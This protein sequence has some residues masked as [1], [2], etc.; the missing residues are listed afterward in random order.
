MQTEV[1]A[2]GNDEHLVHVRLPQSLYDDVYAVQL[3]KLTSKARLPGFRPGKMPQNMVEKQFAPQAHEDTINEL[4]QRHYLEA[5]E[6]S[7]LTPAIQPEIDLPAV[8]VG[9]GFEFTL[10]VTTWPVVAAD[11]LHTLAVT[12]TTVRVDESDVQAVIDRLSGS[13]VRYEIEEGR[14]AEKGDQL[15]IDFEGFLGD[16]PF[17]GGKGENVPLVLGEGRFIPGFEE[18]LTGAAANEQRTLN[19]TFP[20]Q[21]QAAHL[22]GQAARFECRVRSVGRPVTAENED[23]LATMLGFEDGAALRADIEKRLGQEA[24][25]SSYEAT[26]NSAFDALLAAHSV[27]LPAGLV[28]QEMDSAMRRMAQ[29]MKQQGM[30]VDMT[31]F[32]EPSLQDGV[33]ARAERSLKLSVLL[34]SVRDQGSL[35]VSEETIEAE[36]ERMAQHYPT[37][38]HE[39]FKKWMRGQRDQFE[40]MQERLLEQAC[41]A[42]ILG[43]AKRE[44]R[45]INLA[46]WQSEREQ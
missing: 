34:Q 37:E 5:L 1:K 11:K 36:L 9:A 18:Q 7:G 16:T 32:N 14:A 12:E 24:G 35:T 39:E 45:S 17:D 2:L 28:R 29:N 13:Q 43:Q 46:E 21:Y 44:S 4:V 40:A 10:K 27:A 3:K 20:E 31:M 26:R 25:L 42:Y 33:R 22:A 30:Q 8:A 38:Q 23:A 15:H 41:V 6:A 19:V